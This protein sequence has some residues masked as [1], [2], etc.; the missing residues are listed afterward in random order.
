MEQLLD[1]DMTT[2]AFP[3]CALGEE[4]FVNLIDQSEMNERAE[5]CA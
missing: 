2:P 5:I 1:T 3:H 4:Y